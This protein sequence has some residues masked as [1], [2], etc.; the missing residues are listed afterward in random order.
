M[1]GIE[2]PEITEAELLA[3]LLATYGVVVGGSELTRALGF[4]TQSAFRKASERGALKLRL[5]RMPGRRGRFA[6][7][8]ELATWLWWQRQHPEQRD[9]A[10]GVSTE[11]I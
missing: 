1:G 11:G 4:R 7:T 9:S 5:F 2:A 8:T 3:S 6:L 10:G